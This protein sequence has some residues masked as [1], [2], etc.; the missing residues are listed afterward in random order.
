MELYNADVHV[1]RDWFAFTVVVYEMYL[2]HAQLSQ[3]WWVP[4]K[5]HKIDETH[6]KQASKH[7]GAE[8]RLLPYMK[9]ESTTAPAAAG[10]S[11]RTH[12]STTKI[13]RSQNS[14]HSVD[15]AINHMWDSYVKDGK[16]C[17]E[18][19]K[20]CNRDRG[21][22]EPY[23][24]LGKRM[25]EHAPTSCAN[26]KKKTQVQKQVQQHAVPPPTR[27]ATTHESAF[28][29]MAADGSHCSLLK[30]LELQ[31]ACSTHFGIAN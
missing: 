6:S 10:S 1:N 26:W 5:V 20:E 11:S 28:R 30:D 19:D 9:P 22:F 18:A 2:D 13:D 16:M 8:A 12:R 29:F 15:D 17:R 31:K 14:S 23:L 3:S 27:T 25:C 7:Y 21:R 24:R 4:D